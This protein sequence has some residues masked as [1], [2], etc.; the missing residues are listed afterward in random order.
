V[1]DLVFRHVDDVPWQEVKAQMHGERR[2]GVHLRIVEWGERCAFIYT[3]YDP[4]VTLEVHGHNSDHVIYVLEGSVSISGVDCRPG[5]M[6]LLEHGA[7]FGP[8][9][10]GPEGTDLVEFY[11]GDPRSWS[12]D[13]A[14]YTALLAA[15]G[16]EPL[17]DP[18]ID[19]PTRRDGS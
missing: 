17:P 3:H 18:V 2:V 14:G 8:I 6:V 19:G 15:R 10:A 12:A 5:M 7:T 1:A 13:P 9:I 11:T 4:G 16:I